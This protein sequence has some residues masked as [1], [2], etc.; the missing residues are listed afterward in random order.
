MLVRRAP[1]PWLGAS[2]FAISWVLVCVFTLFHALREGRKPTRGV[3]LR[4]AGCARLCAALRLHRDGRGE[5]LGSLLEHKVLQPS[6]WTA[7]PDGTLL[8]ARQLGDWEEANGCADGS[9]AGN[10]AVQLL[11]SVGR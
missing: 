5:L 10:L 7:V 11:N 8:A 2:S 1:Q 3:A 6:S 4:P 9:V